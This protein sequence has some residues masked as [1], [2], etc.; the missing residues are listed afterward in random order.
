MKYL[1][2]ANRVIRG[3]LLEILIIIIDLSGSMDAKDWKPSRKAGAIK[4]N[5]ELVKTEAQ[6]H[7]QDKVGI[8]GFG[9][10]AEILHEP[11]CLS[12]GAG[13]LLNALSTLPDMGYT[14]FKAALQL[15]E[16]CL[17]GRPVAAGRNAGSGVVSGFLSWLLYDKPLRASNYIR[18]TLS[19]DNCLRRI[20]MLTDG[21]YNEGG[22]P[23]KVARRLKDAGV[24]IDCIG[25]GGS[26]TDVKEE[27]LKEIASRNADGSV[28]YCFIGDQQQLIRKYESLAHHIRPA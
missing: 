9:T 3:I 11:V 4:A 15:A 5:K 1:N 7:P 14:N 25:I 18:E 19:N 10:D 22:S 20:I 21:D 23:L 6:Y 17:S 2:F 8:I 12:Q 26:P 13:S 16:A 27:N 28:R 24:V